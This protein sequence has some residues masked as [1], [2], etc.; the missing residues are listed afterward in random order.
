MTTGNF[1]APLRLPFV[2][3]QP[4]HPVDADDAPRLVR[5]TAIVLQLV[6]PEIHKARDKA[7]KSESEEVS[8]KEVL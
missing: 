8:D 3:L 2:L 7:S 4:P 5:D 1:P 6:F